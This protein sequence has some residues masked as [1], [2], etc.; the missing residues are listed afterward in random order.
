M[1]RHRPHRSPLAAI[2]AIL[3][4]VT[5]LAA[6]GDDAATDAGD[7]T[8]E[9]A[10]GDAFPV[11]V[12]HEYGT[13]EIE[14]APVRVVSVGYTEQDA[15]LALGITPVAVTDWYGDQ[16]YG[17]WPWAQDELGDATP[18]LLDATDGIDV[19]A[20][21]ALDP[22]LIVGT[23]SGMDED[24]Y[25]LL[26]KVAPTI[27]HPK[28]ADLYFSDWR[29]Q[30]RLIGQ[31]VGLADEADELIAGI[32]EQFEAAAAAHPEFKGKQAIFLQNAFY[33][34]AAIAYQDGLSTSFLTDL[35]FKIPA[36]LD[37]FEQESQAYIPLEQLSVLNDGDV[38]IWGTEK[39]E[40]RAAL[41][42]EAVYNALDRVQDGRLVF[43]D[44]LTAGAIYFTSL[45][46]L[47]YV[48]E[49]LVPALAS[50]LAGEGPATI[51]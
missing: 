51:S 48:L 13:T 10:S 46:S 5:T 47:P 2:L 8:E 30:T 6:C 19:E 40:D 17:V 39:P 43:T 28:G 50:T 4:L 44:G 1:L 34:G 18:V 12:E 38:L 32:D 15:L 31:A 21:A 25:E 29:T 22:D 33:D 49:K 27:A 7:D 11:T 35:G 45:L 23:N 36:S 37:A 9:V 26:S 16:P 41:E 20:V 14:A 3:L 42:T 24:T